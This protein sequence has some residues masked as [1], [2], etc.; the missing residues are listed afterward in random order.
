MKQLRWGLLLAGVLTLCAGAVFAQ[1][2]EGERPMG[3]P[4]GPHIFGK[5]TAING[6][7]LTIEGPQ[8][9]VQTI[10][11]NTETHLLRQQKP[12]T[13]ADFKVGDFVGA[14]GRFD[15]K[16][17]FVAAGMMGDDKP[18]QRG[19]GGPMGGPDERMRGPGGER[20][21]PGS[22]R[23]NFNR[24]NMVA[25]KITAINGNVIT[26]Q[27]R[28]GKEQ[29]F[30]VGNETSFARNEEKASLADLKV[31]DFVGAIGARGENGQLN[32][33]QVRG[34]DKP[35]QR[36]GPGGRPPGERP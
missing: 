33:T 23:E 3:P 29:T 28:D 4:P 20:R 35:P 16:Q 14:I 21:G 22:P 18:P 26:V 34:G 19:P 24:E 10:Y 7:T 13:L 1:R 32:A 8:G 17:Q 30:T 27:G 9:E 5:V 15:E 12:A 36:G 25:G 2:P 31:G 11:V 6:N